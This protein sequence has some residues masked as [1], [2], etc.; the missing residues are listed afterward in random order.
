MQPYNNIRLNRIELLTLVSLTI[1][2]LVFTA[3]PDMKTIHDYGSVP[4]IL[5]IIALLIPAIVFILSSVAW[6]RHHYRKCCSKRNNIERSLVADNDQ[7]HD[8]VVDPRYRT[9]SLNDALRYQ[10]VDSNLSTS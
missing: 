3:F 10:S 6:L 7:E 1:T 4:F 2:S 5:I 8:D 9:H